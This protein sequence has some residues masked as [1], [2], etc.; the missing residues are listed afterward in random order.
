MTPNLKTPSQLFR[1]LSDEISEGGDTNGRGAGGG[2]GF[3]LH[4]MPFRHNGSLFNVLDAIALAHSTEVPYRDWVANNLYYVYR[5]YTI[6]KLS[7]WLVQSI[8]SIV[9]QDR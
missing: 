6:K 1:N 7:S 3:P 9:L 4:Q 2:S 8:N 5:N